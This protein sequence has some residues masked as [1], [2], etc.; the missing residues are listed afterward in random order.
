[1]HYSRVGTI[2]VAGHLA[3]LKTFPLDLSAM[4]EN[5]TVEDCGLQLI[6]N[7]GYDRSLNRIVREL[8]IHLCKL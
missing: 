4:V 1:M 8:K 3:V 2:Q 6:E 5:F 7:L